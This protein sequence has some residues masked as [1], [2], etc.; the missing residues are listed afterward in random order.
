MAHG[1]PRAGPARQAPGR[2]EEIDDFLTLPLHGPLTK[3]RYGFGYKYLGQR[4][5][6]LYA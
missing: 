1:H 2:E 4:A 6:N 3:P 5:G